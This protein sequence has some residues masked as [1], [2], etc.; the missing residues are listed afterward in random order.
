MDQVTVDVVVSNPIALLGQP[1]S[2]ISRA[3]NHSAAPCRW[4]GDVRTTWRDAKGLRIERARTNVQPATVLWQP[5]QVLEEHQ[6]WDQRFADG[7]PAA[8][9][10]ALVGV[11]WG[12]AGE[13][14]VAGLATFTIVTDLTPPTTVPPR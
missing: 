10:E 4:P 14:P 13:D 8:I 5:G 12:P 9:G 6:T 7:T 3:L 2:M 11:S 1:V